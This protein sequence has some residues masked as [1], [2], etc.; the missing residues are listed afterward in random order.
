MAFGARCDNAEEEGIHH[1]PD[2]KHSDKAAEHCCVDAGEIQHQGMS[3]ADAVRAWVMTKRNGKHKESQCRRDSG[4]G[5][6]EVPVEIQAI[7]KTMQPLVLTHHADRGDGHQ[8]DSLAGE[9]AHKALQP[10]V[11]ARL[12]GHEGLSAVDP[13]T[14]GLCDSGQLQ[15]VLWL[16]K[17]C[18]WLQIQARL[19]I[20][21]CERRTI[22]GIGVVQPMA[23]RHAFPLG[24]A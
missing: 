24:G 5:D 8:G 21:S 18:Q 22:S 6:Q 19:N 3:R 15:V 20:D 23:C 11:L 16:T 13:R 10:V 1:V 2:P 9:A 12:E 14:V 17:F 7:R 4:D